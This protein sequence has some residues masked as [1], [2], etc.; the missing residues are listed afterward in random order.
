MTAAKVTEIQA[1]LTQAGF[2][3]GAANG[4]LT[5]ATLAAVQRYQAAKGLPVDKGA[6][7]NMD[8]VKALGL[9]VK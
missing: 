1:A 3:P 9:G 6:Y 8:T 2:D 4:Q 5:A 7:I